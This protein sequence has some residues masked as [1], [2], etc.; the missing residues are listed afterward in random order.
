MTL[1]VC[2]RCF[3]KPLTAYVFHKN[4]KFIMV[5]KIQLG[6][7]VGFIQY[8]TLPWENLSYFLTHCYISSLKPLGPKNRLA[9]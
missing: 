3:R 5:V 2:M 7:V 4:G 8:L 1:C 6:Y 9:T